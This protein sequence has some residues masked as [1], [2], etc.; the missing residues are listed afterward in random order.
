MPIWSWRKQSRKRKWSRKVSMAIL[1]LILPL[2]GCGLWDFDP[3]D[4]EKHEDAEVK[5]RESGYSVGIHGKKLYLKKKLG[6]PKS[7]D[8]E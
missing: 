6:R 8:S 2:T 4:Y 7:R 5:R 1:S 3:Y